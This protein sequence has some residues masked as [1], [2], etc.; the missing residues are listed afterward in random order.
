MGFWPTA[1]PDQMEA[2]ARLIAD[3]QDDGDESRENPAEWIVLR[4]EVVERGDVVDSS[5]EHDCPGLRRHLGRGVP[6]QDPEEDRRLSELEHSEAP[7]CWVRTRLPIN[8]SATTSFE[9][10]RKCCLVF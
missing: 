8:P 6:G 4:D 10:D 3:R 2:Q 7:W 9:N 5:S 1:I